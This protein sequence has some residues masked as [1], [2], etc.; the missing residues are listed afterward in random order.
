MR[1]ARIENGAV[2]EKREFTVVPDPNPAKGLDWRPCPAATP[3][4]YD[5]AT[6]VR[7]GPTYVVGEQEVTEQWAVRPKTAQE[8]AADDEARKDSELS[9]LKKA[10]FEGFFIHENRIR[11]REGQAPITRQQLLAWFRNQ[12]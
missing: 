11:A 10:I 2:V 12:V 7:T 1:Y 3:P 6:Q 9:A 5:A 8:L 4:A